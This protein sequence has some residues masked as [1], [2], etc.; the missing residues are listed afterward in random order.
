MIEEDFHNNICTYLREYFKYKVLGAEDM[1]DKEYYF[2]ESDLT[3]YIQAIQKDTWDKLYQEHYSSDTGRQII[4]TIKEDLE[5]SPLWLVIRNGILVKG[6][7]IYLYTPRPRNPQ[8]TQQVKEFEQNIFAYKK[9]FYFDKNNKEAIDLVLYLNGLP[10]ITTEIKHHG[11]T[12]EESTYI[13]AINQYL[14][15]IH[16]SEP[17]RPY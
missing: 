2:V 11:E 15:L 4:K 6:E 14:S 3:D 5:I 9:E 13:D 8:N 10:I 1:S 12:G 17:T 16:I 7:K